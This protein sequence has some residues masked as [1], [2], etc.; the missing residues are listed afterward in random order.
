VTAS[1]V[2]DNLQLTVKTRDVEQFKEFEII[3]APKTQAVS[4]FLS[5][6]LNLI[7][8]DVWVASVPVSEKREQGRVTYIFR[9]APAALAQSA[10][11]IHASNYAPATHRSPF[12][13]ALLGKRQVE[14]VMGGTIYQ[15][16][17]KTFTQSQ[18]KS[19]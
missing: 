2:Y 15:M 17:L 4:P 5:A 6:Q 16:R 18:T 11:E 3:L 8:Q 7:T 12:R 1:G 13:T 19:N 10:F 14:Q 9:V